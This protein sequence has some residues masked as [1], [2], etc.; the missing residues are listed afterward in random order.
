MALLGLFAAAFL[1]A[2]VF[3]MQSEAVLAALFLAGEEPVSL[4][5]LVA[6][7]GNV[8]GSTVNWILGR[9]LL[10]FRDRR[11]FPVSDMQL[12]RA[13]GWYRRWG[14]WS[15]LGSWL[16]VVGDPLTLVAGALREPLPTF[17]LLVTLAKGGR[18]VAVVA[19]LDRL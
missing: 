19:L 17:L 13:T 4:L 3:P 2:T 5:L 18:Y 10:S 11:W 1:A 7:F 9:F 12:A 16:P 14:R 6:T 15:L 8:L